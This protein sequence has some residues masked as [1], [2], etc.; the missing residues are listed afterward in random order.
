MTKMINFMQIILAIT[1]IYIIKYVTMKFFQ[2]FKTHE[3]YESALS[4]GLL[5]ELRVIVIS[6]KKYK[7]LISQSFIFIL[8]FLMNSLKSLVKALFSILE[9]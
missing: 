4:N 8:L 1:S 2:Y 5:P 6:K 7:R 9:T 3:E